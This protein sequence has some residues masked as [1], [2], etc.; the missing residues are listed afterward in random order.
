MWRQ[1]VH[2][3]FK[4]KATALFNQPGNFWKVFKVPGKTINTLRPTF[5]ELFGTGQ[6]QAL[7]REAVAHPSPLRVS[8]LTSR[9]R[10]QMWPVRRATCP[11]S[12]VS[13]A[14]PCPCHSAGA[15]ARA[16]LGA[17]NQR[18]HQV[19]PAWKAHFALVHGNGGYIL[20]QESI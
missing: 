17:A 4:L 18:K 20:Q 5:R 8:G 16:R 11:V 1:V 6:W 13:P 3:K 9:S 15:P 10:S 14:Q 12:P 7:I 19:E 2:T